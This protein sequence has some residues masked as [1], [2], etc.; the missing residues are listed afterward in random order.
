MKKSTKARIK[1][2]RETLLTL[3]ALEME[4]GQGGTGMTTAHLTLCFCA[5][6]AVCFSYQ[7]VPVCTPP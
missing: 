1:L 4:A 3:A 6:T 5:A 7:P 2:H